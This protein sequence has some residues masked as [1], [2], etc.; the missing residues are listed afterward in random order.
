MKKYIIPFILV[1]V[2]FC[3]CTED[4]SIDPTIMPPST[5][6]GLNTFGCL[7]DGWIYAGGRFSKPHAYYI[8]S[9]DEEEEHVVINA[10]INS[11]EYISFRI[12]QPSKGSTVTYTNATYSSIN[13][14]SQK[15]EDGTVDIIRFDKQKHIIS[16]TFEGGNIKEGR[17]DIIYAN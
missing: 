8:P 13:N 4:A 15:L 6:E 14:D 7:M 11:G 9:N 12:N 3:S 1:F 16:G 17:F 2:F 10:E 5:T